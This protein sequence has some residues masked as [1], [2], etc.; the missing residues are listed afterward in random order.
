[1]SRCGNPNL[2]QMGLEGGST[3][4]VRCLLDLKAGVNLPYAWVGKGK[5]DSGQPYFHLGTGNFQLGGGWAASDLYF[6][7]NHACSN[8]AF[9]SLSLTPLTY[10]R[11]G[12]TGAWSET[13][14]T[15][16]SRP[17]SHPGRGRGRGLVARA[18]ASPPCGLGCPR[19]E[20]RLAL[21]RGSP[22]GS[23]SLAPLRLASRTP[24]SS[25][26]PHRT[27]VKTSTAK[28]VLEQLRE[29]PLAVSSPSSV[30]ASPQPG[31][32]CSP[33]PLPLG[34]RRPRG[35]THAGAQAWEPA[36][37]RTRAGAAP[38]WIATR[39]LSCVWGLWGGNSC[40]LGEGAGSEWV[41]GRAFMA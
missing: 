40:L 23:Q 25:R 9:G 24:P 21:A 14:G 34:E 20:A 36:R 31:A 8:F 27:Q 19:A 29:S 17:P 32:P 7:P 39:P 10:S 4:H 16:L 38:R 28:V 11:I 26:P 1:M 33:L 13:W 12:V 3:N 2:N 37:P 18:C 35:C 15:R 22:R 5:T 30:P 41:K 6:T